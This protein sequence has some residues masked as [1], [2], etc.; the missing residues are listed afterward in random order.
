MI[1]THFGAVDGAIK[2]A[3]LKWR[4]P[5]RQPFGP[6]HPVGIPSLTKYYKHPVQRPLYG[7]WTLIYTAQG[8]SARNSFVKF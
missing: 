4:G 1:P 6:P 3:I 7:L 2:G 8:T 5:A